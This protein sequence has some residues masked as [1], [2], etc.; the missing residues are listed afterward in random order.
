LRASLS[1]P[2][3]LAGQGVIIASPDFG[4]I[5]TRLQ[6]PGEFTVVDRADV[7]RG[8]RRGGYFAKSTEATT[9]LPLC[10]SSSMSTAPFLPSEKV[11]LPWSLATPLVTLMELKL[12]SVGCWPFFLG[13]NC[14]AAKE[15]GR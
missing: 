3:A 15:T 10:S 2:F 13:R 14:Y 11:A 5:C 4:A 12:H 8:R 6:N 9:H 1:H 7:W